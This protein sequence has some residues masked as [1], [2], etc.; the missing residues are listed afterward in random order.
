MLAHLQQESMLP[1]WCL[2]ISKMLH[3]RGR[4]RISS[5]HMLVHWKLDNILLFF[6]VPNGTIFTVVLAYMYIVL[7]LVRNTLELERSVQEGRYLQ[8]QEKERPIY[9]SRQKILSAGEGTTIG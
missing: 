9:L 6:R 1:T 5:S 8:C 2:L 7:I 3:S 4:Y